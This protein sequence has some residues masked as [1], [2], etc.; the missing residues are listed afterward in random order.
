MVDDIAVVAGFKHELVE[1]ELNG[2]ASIA[3]NH[4]YAKT[5][6]A[7][8][9][10]IGIGKYC[11]EVVVIDGDV[12]F[13]RA[14]IERVINTDGDLIC[15]TPNISTSNPVFV[16][17]ESEN[18]VG[19]TRD[20]RQLE[21]AGIGRFASR[22]LIDAHGYMCDALADFLPMRWEL[23]DSIEIDTADDLHEAEKWT[24]RTE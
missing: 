18:V 16:E 15:V 12:L 10:R 11:G 5:G 2:R 24:A 14:N 20:S 22:Y 4:A 1:G 8:S 13:T 7:D 21:W 23:I 17:I 6:V 9:A 19:F 3:I